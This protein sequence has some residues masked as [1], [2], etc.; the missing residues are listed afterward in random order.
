M[1]LALVSKNFVVGVIDDRLLDNGRTNEVFNLLGD[2]Y[3]FTIEFSDGLEKI[4]DVPAIPSFAIAFHASSMRIILRMPFNLRILEIKTSM[5]MMV[6][7]GKS[8]G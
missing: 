8:I 5:I 2:Y 7:T 1:I 4:F 6:T 3:C